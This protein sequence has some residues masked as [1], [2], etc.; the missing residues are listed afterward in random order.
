MSMGLS[1]HWTIEA[2]F[3]GPSFW[4]VQYFGPELD[5]FEGGMKAHLVQIF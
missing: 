4:A 5:P 3:Y 2:A 1:L